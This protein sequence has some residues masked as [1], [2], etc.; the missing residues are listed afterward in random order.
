M[1]Q[2]IKFT[3]NLWPDTVERKMGLNEDQK[4][5]LVK[6][7][8]SLLDEIREELSGQKDK[9]RTGPQLAEMGEMMGLKEEPKDD[10]S[11]LI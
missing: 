6:L 7:A 11:Q 8:D 9:S 2:T 4:N 1:F 10:Y 3:V 5:L